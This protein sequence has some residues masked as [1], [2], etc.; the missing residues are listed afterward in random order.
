MMNFVMYLE[1][2]FSVDFSDFEFDVILID[3]VNDIEAL[4]DSKLA[5]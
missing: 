5:R 2:A 4:V 3:S 1:E